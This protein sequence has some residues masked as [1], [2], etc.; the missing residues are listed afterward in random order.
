MTPE[1]KEKIREARRRDR[2][3]FE[4]DLFTIIPAK[5]EEK[6]PSIPEGWS[7]SKSSQSTEEK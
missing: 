5:A 3:F 4:S 6:S 7:T 2:Q 1:S